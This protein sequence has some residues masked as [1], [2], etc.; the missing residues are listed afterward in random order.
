MLNDK[1]YRIGVFSGVVAG[2]LV[3]VLTAM[4]FGALERREQ[5]HARNWEVSLAE[6]SPT[7]APSFGS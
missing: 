2:I 7:V 5:T 4:A 3:L 1:E 6:A